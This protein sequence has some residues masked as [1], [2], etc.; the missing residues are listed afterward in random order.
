MR[1]AWA[2]LVDRTMQHAANTIVGIG[3]YARC[4]MIRLASPRRKGS[5]TRVKWGEPTKAVFPGQSPGNHVTPLAPTMST[6]SSGRHAVVRG[7][8]AIPE[9]PDPGIGYPQVRRDRPIATW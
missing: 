6:A 9:P 1:S 8:A 5:A 2:F 4:R 3:I 7:S